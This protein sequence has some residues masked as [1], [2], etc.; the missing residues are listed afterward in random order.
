[1]LSKAVVILFFEVQFNHD[2]N[3]H[4]LTVFVQ[5]STYNYRLHRDEGSCI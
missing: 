2:L 4:V 1:M 3:S 5:W